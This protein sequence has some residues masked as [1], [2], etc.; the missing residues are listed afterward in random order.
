[1]NP[2]SEA[3]YIAFEEDRRIGSGD[4][5]E[6]ARAAR[7]ALGRHPNASILIFNGQTSAVVEVGR[8]SCRE[9]VLYTV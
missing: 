3:G 7:L 6:V 9:R 5:R 2:A 1:M 4:L 8:A